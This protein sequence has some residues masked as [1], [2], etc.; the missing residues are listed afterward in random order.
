MKKL[1]RREFI[2]AG[3][4]SGFVA[5]AGMTASVNTVNAK[6][7]LPYD[8]VAIKGG[9]PELMF[10]RGI[11]AMGGMTKFVKKGQTVVIKPNIGWDVS[12]ERAGNTNPGLVKRI[13]E[14]CFNAGA[15]EVYV[16]DHSCDNWRKTY[17][18]SGIEEAVKSAGGKIVSGG[19]EK[20]YR[21]VKIGKGISLK[22]DKVHELILDS[23]VF[24]NV[25]I[26]KN[27]GATKLTVCMKN[28]MGVNWDRRYWHRNDLH[29][30]IADFATKIQPDLNIVDAYRVMQTHGPRGV[31]VDDVIMMKAQI[32]STDMVA[33][34]AAATKFFG[35]KPEDIPHIKIAHDAGTGN[36]NLD[37]LR[38]KRIKI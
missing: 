24:I 5:A 31:S 26:L 22:Q 37:K 13:I 17:K 30:C 19:S 28:L 9:E 1:D 11:K 14:H 6:P 8:L 20:Y 4:A 16:F 25:P 29:Q 10:D 2:K 36:M 23:D 32:I 18:T 33:A 35:L 12:P 7:D 27:H 3:L 21:K 34:D 38:I 15:K